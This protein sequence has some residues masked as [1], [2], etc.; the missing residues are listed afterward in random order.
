MEIIDKLMT[1]TDFAADIVDAQLGAEL[2][3]KKVA[4]MKRALFLF[5]NR[6]GPGKRDRNRSVLSVVFFR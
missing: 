2:L 1:G 4:G 5:G 3:Q 6:R